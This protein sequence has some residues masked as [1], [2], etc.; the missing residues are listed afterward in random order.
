VVEQFSLHS[1]FRFVNFLGLSVVP[2]SVQDSS[3]VQIVTY[4][5]NLE[6]LLFIPAIINC[7]LSAGQL[8]IL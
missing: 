7:H 4:A 3:F 6:V 5:L 1:E 2:V 8:Y